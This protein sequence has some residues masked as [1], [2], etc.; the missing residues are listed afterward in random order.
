MS[1][2]LSKRIIKPLSILKRAVGEISKGDLE[3]EVIEVGDQE[4]MELCAD[5]EKMRIQLKDTTRLKKKYDDNRT[6]LVSSIFA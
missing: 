1:Y 4:I 2:L 6:M 5:F 3:V